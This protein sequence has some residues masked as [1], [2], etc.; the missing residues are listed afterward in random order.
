MQAGT[1]LGIVGV[2]ASTSLA[3][4]LFGKGTLLWFSHLRDKEF[5]AQN[6]QIALIHGV[7]IQTQSPKLHLPW[8][9]IV[10]RAPITMMSACVGP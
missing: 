10:I 8:L 1:I 3:W 7:R 5:D 2:H 6:M 4:H 9:L